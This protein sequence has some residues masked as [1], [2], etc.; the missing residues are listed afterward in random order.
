MM[1]NKL[2]KYEEKKKVDIVH[3]MHYIK[4]LN[5]LV[6]GYI[7]M[8]FNDNKS[9]NGAQIHISR[10][11]EN[12]VSNNDQTNFSIKSDTEIRIEN[13]NKTHHLHIAL[14]GKYNVGKSTISYRFTTRQLLPS[15]RPE[16]ALPYM[17]NKEIDGYKFQYELEINENFACAECECIIWIYDVTERDTYEHIINMIEE[18]ES[19]KYGIVCGNKCDLE[20]NRVISKK[21]GEQ[22]VNRLASK[23]N[24][25]FFETSAKNNVNINSMFEECAKIYIDTHIQN[26]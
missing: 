17:K 5:H 6:V 21:E 4:R 10:L 1:G 9:L 2:N 12:F 16:T 25:T 14:T 3:S 13:K 7:R 22:F 20:S 24:V 23:Y 8:N 18:N 11:C 26:I 19:W 15:R